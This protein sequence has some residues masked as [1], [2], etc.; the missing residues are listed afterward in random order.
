MS[1]SEKLYFILFTEFDN[2][3]NNFQLESP[4]IDET[5]L[6]GSTEACE[7]VRE[8]NATRRLNFSGVLGSVAPS[9]SAAMETDLTTSNER[10][11][12]QTPSKSSKRTPS[13]VQ[14]GN[15][16]DVFFRQNLMEQQTNHQLQKELILIHKRKAQIE[17]EQSQIELEKRKVELEMANVELEKSREMAKIHL[18]KERRMAAIEI[19]QMQNQLQNN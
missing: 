6:H 12:T 7:N 9:T 2:D 15:S 17:L 4:E 13:N 19:E 14:S 16:A 10:Q 5:L 18:D 8:S 1:H 11:S 3:D